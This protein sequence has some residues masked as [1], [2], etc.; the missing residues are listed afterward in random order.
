M[1]VKVSLDFCPRR[2]FPVLILCFFLYSNLCSAR[3]FTYCHFRNILRLS[4]SNVSF[5]KGG[6]VCDVR[7]DVRLLVSSALV[8]DWVC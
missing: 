2:C 6:R 1:W 3:E 4:L 7:A 5:F 8:P